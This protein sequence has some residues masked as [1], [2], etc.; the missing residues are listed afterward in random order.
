MNPSKFRK[1]PV[2]IEAC[3][4]MKDTLVEVARWCSGLAT[5][6]MTWDYDAGAY[7]HPDWGYVFGAQY[8]DVGIVIRTPEDNMFMFARLGGWIIRDVQ[9]QF[10]P[11]KPEI[12][13]A[14][15]EALSS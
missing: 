8:R 5:T 6:E 2:E 11:C 7:K 14:T 9:G 3:E 13:A 10:Y 4:V 1:K 15:Y 12:F